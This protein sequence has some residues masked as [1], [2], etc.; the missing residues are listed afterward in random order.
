MA[1]GKGGGKGSGRKGGGGA[2]GA[3]GGS[4]GG[5]RAGGA[6]VEL[7]TKDSALV[8][9]LKSASGKLKSWSS[10]MGKIG[11]G[12]LA[13][14]ASILAPVTALL[15][16][17]IG[18]A[19]AIGDVA[20]IFNL[21]AE[22]ASRMASAY[23]IA[24]GSIDELQ[25]A[26]GKLTKTNTTG[27]PLDEYL[28]S[29]ADALGEIDD[30]SERFTAAS[31]IFGPKFA[32]KFIDTGSDLRGLLS[33]API[34]SKTEL[35]NAKAFRMEWSRV[36][37]V[38]QNSILPVLGYLKPALAETSAL[39]QRNAAYLPAVAG[40]GA[41]LVALGTGALAASAGL[42]VAGMGLAG[43]AGIA[44]A[45]ASPIGIATVAI[46]GGTAAWLKY[47]ES[48]QSALR[49]LNA[50]ATDVWA[51]ISSGW[52]GVQNALEAGDLGL[53]AQ[54]GLG[55]LEVEWERIMASM[56]TAWIKLGAFLKEAG[57]A[58]AFAIESAWTQ[59][60]GNLAVGIASIGEQIGALDKGT[61]K[62]VHKD[63]KAA[64]GAL[65]EQAALDSQRIGAEKAA[66][67]EAAEANLRAA[68]ENVAKLIED[69]KVRNAAG[70]R[71]IPAL[72][73]AM[74]AANGFGTSSKGAFNFGN[75]GQF[76]GGANGGFQ[77]K[78]LKLQEDLKKEMQG[79]NEALR[80]IP[81]AR[82]Q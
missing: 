9:G 41:G 73:P 10:E 75:A 28:L 44:G 14:G 78:Q 43:L 42:S 67:I 48:G 58:W 11:A 21:S 55:A 46:A 49:S 32:A 2:G 34:L 22:A 30:A 76:F 47:T 37:I 63:N 53:A 74:A 62:G 50:T 1:R 3:S 33:S 15:T 29:V 82:F 12:G 23:E 25:V 5:I 8:K 64:L 17:G 72:E 4:A 52:Q 61:T 7:F 27:R 13:A 69:A 35:D 51:N 36:G 66:A 18:R 60:I 19:E 70:G 31:E 26:L 6:F 56:K 54:I 45:I 38:F 24:G 71:D 59:A 40:I 68:K 16:S 80:N 79:V 81:L 77:D 39:L 20:D 57:V 65:R